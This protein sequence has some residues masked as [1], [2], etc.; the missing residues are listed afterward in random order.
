MPDTHWASIDQPLF[1][2]A[3]DPNA[4]TPKPLIGLV[5]DSEHLDTD[6]TAAYRQPE[7]SWRRMLPCIPPPVRLQ[8]QYQTNYENR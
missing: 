1:D 3:K 6:R 5:G 4:L 8:V 2:N 7:A